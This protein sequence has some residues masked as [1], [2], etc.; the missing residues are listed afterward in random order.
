MNITFSNAVQYSQSEFIGEKQKNYEDMVVYGFFFLLL[1]FCFSF[2]CKM[3]MQSFKHT[4]HVNNRFMR[5]CYLSDSY[6]QFVLCNRQTVKCVKMVK[7]VRIKQEKKRWWMR[8]TT[9]TTTKNVKNLQSS[10]SYCKFT[11]FRPKA[12]F[13]SDHGIIYVSITSNIQMKSDCDIERKQLHYW[14]YWRK[15]TMKRWGENKTHIKM[16]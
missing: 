15:N 6:A 12:E 13:R 5:L 1:C 10:L 2:C 11:G 4:A 3:Q 9:T 8:A 14:D 7:Q 16:K